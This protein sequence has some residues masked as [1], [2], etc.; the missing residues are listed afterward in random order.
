M[1]IWGVAGVYEM[2]IRRGAFAGF[3]SK[4]AVDI[5]ST[6][7]LHT[8]RGL[9]LDGEA[10]APDPPTPVDPHPNVRPEGVL[11]DAGGPPRFHLGPDDN[12]MD[13]GPATML[14]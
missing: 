10:C 13:Y 8:R 14:P 6:S 2:G 12:A 7:T 5:N 1:P 9:F 11:V 3:G 4:S